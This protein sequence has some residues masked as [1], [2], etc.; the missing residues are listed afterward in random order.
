MIVTQ[1]RVTIVRSGSVVPS[2]HCCHW[3]PRCTSWHTHPS[4]PH[5]CHYH[6]QAGPSVCALSPA[7]ARCRCWCGATVALATCV[8]STSSSLLL[9]PLSIAPVVVAVVLPWHWPFVSRRHCCRGTVVLAVA[10]VVIAVVPHRHRTIVALATLVALAV[11]GQL[12]H[13][14]D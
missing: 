9:P 12:M 13:G 10:I 8:T 14:H 1:R 6:R 11:D 7:S 4:P 3:H 2:H 5:G